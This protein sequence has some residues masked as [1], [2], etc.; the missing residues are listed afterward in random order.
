MNLSEDDIF[1]LLTSSSSRP[2]PTWWQ[3]EIASNVIDSIVHADAIVGVSK[4]FADH[5]QHVV[6]VLELVSQQR[7]ALSSSLKPVIE[8]AQRTLL[9]T[10]GEEADASEAYASFHEALF[11]LPSLS[12]DHIFACIEEINALTAGVE[13]MMQS[14]I[15]ALTVIWEALHIDTMERSKFWGDIDQNIKSFGANSKDLFEF[16]QADVEEWVAM[17]TLDASK[18]CQVLNTRLHKLEEVHSE[19]ERLR[20]KQD[21]KSRIISLDSEIRI[22][23]ATLA[24]FEEKKCNKQRLLTK[25]SGSSTL[26]REERYRRQMQGKFTTKLEHL[27]AAVKAWKETDG[28]D[29][30]GNILSEEVRV[31][32]ENPDKMDS[33]VEKR[34]EFMHLRTVQP[35]PAAKRPPSKTPGA[36][37]LV[38]RQRSGSSAESAGSSDSDKSNVPGWPRPSSRTARKPGSDRLPVA[39]PPANEGISRKRRAET[40]SGSRS[41]IKP[42][43]RRRKEEPGALKRSPFSPNSQAPQKKKDKSLSNQP[44]TSKRDTMMPFGHVLGDQ[45]PQTASKENFP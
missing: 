41:P 3:Q 6:G 20:S 29:F 10:V 38:K 28:H 14:E 43:T 22:L 25:K 13:A 39:A 5:L 35:K 9:A 44:K 42:R 1:L 8:R 11:N 32:L 30:E 36:S 15:E 27:A 37:P 17:S 12:K 23:S 33:L 24:E 2:I 18:A 4:V 45:S 34:T 7:G 26:L 19:V 21:A 31:L 40:S 16:S